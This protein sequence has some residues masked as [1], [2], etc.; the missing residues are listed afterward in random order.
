MTPPVTAQL[1]E[2]PPALHGDGRHYFGLGWPALEWLERNVTADMTTLETG[3]GGSTIVFA[4]AG[5]DHTAISPDPDEH[6]RLVEWC[7]RRDISTERVH[8]LAEPSHTAL[9]GT[10]YPHPLDVVLVDGAHGFPYPALDWFFT[11]AHLKVGGVTIL[12]DAFLPSVNTVVRYLRDSPHWEMEQPLGYRTVAFRK[13]GDDISFDWVGS[14]FD[15]RPRFDYLS[16]GAR[17]V[18][19]ARHYL[20]DT[21]PRGQRLLA[22][23]RRGRG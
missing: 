22:R 23:V 9:Q 19:L 8:F 13:L 21:S 12:D 10:W 3:A 17:A 7:E 11:A 1:R 14:R 16:P 4:A 20:I 2:D 6:R 15:R 5:S 18:A